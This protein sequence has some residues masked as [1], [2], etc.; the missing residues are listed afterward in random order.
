[1]QKPIP[2]FKLLL[3]FIFC[4]AITISG[5]KNDDDT[6][7]EPC[8]NQYEADPPGQWF[9]GDFHVH[10]T[11]A[12]NDTGG[13]SFPADIKATALE[14]GLDFVVLTDHSN[15]T[16]SD[17]NTTF[18]DPALFNKGPEFTY[19]QTAAD[20]SVV[21][22]FLMICGNEISPRA[23]D[24]QTP[25]GHIGCIP[26][27]LQT[28]DTS[29]VFVDRPMGE[30]TGGNA[31]QQAVDRGCFSIINH[32]YAI[33]KWIA[34]DWESYDYDA[35][36]VWNGT[37]GF[38]L[39]DRK[40]HDAWRCDLL[41]GRN[42][43]AV[44]GSDCHRVFTDAPGAGLDPALGYP[45]TAVFA[46]DFTWN[47]IM[48]GLRAGKTAIFEGDGFLQIDGYDANLCRNETADIRHIRLRG[49]VDANNTTAML[50]LVRA[51][52]CNDNRPDADNAPAISDTLL[53]ERNLSPGE[54]FDID[55]EV[56]GESGVYTA[57]ITANTAAHY[58]ALSRAIVVP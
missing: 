26:A 31:L 41:S 44:G 12:S 46:T 7:T 51:T 6:G 50:K 28:F 11:G 32:P 34:Y 36:E 21:G 53:L 57:E 18:E 3:T 40:G 9:K 38:D 55:I 39:F 8:N 5:C 25:V 22:E 23:V 54:N 29:G 10:A 43:A 48:D 13:N 49:K 15:S 2:N 20:L 35:I 19:W 58:G 16:G 14:R 1:M 17:P 47:A 33:T 30:V 37:I 4:V 56:A 42:T 52:A 45:I 24:N 27:N